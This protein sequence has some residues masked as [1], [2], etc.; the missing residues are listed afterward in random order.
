MTERLFVHTL[1]FPEHLWGDFFR[2]FFA[3]DVLIVDDDGIP[4]PNRFKLEEAKT[5]ENRGFDILFENDLK[6]NNPD[7]LPCLVIED[8]GM[9]ALGV[10][11]NRLA[12]WNV[13]RETSKTRSDLIRSTYVF[14]CCSRDRGESRLLAAIVANAITV[15]YDELLRAGFHKLE[16]WSIGKTTPIK[17]DSDEVYADTPVQI[18]F[19]T[20]QTWKTV[21]SGSG[22]AKRFCLEI[23]P[24][25]LVRYVRM[26]MSLSDPAVAR[27]IATSMELQDPNVNLYINTSL[28]LVDP[29]VD[30]WF[31][32]TSMNVANPLLAERY[33]RTSMRVT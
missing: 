14:H 5:P 1:S 33:V 7:L 25:E 18:S 6:T 22:F 3:Q 16:P 30:E 31:V 21:E 15:F 2:T 23:R 29:L 8:L 24:D 12:N 32:L 11:T 28:N 4:I 27:Y 19:E 20:Q 9:S 13:G 17:N 26:S 10:A